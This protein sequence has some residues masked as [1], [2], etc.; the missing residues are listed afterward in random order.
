MTSQVRTPPATPMAMPLSAAAAALK[1]SRSPCAA[2]SAP[3]DGIAVRRLASRSTCPPAPRASGIRRAFA[4][5]SG[6]GDG[7]GKSEETRALGV[8]IGEVLPRFCLGDDAP[9]LDR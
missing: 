9:A 1:R 2:A 8:A 4:R 5:R 6:S 7:L 3:P